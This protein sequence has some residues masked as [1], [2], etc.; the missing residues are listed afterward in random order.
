MHDH[1]TSL[2]RYII[3]SVEVG[4]F[5]VNQDMEVILWNRF[6]EGGS[7]RKAHEVVGKNLFDCFP[8]LP[9]KWLERKIRNVFLLKN[10]SFTSWEQRPYLFRFPHNRPVTGNI[11]CMRQN[12]TFLPVKDQSGEIQ[13]V[14][15]TLFDVTDTSIY[16]EMLNESLVKLE[17][18]SI[19]DGLTGVYNRRYLEE[20]L[21][22]EFGRIKRYGGTFSFIIIDLDHF[23]K[24]NDTYGHTVGDKVLKIATERFSNYL[25]TADIMGRYGGEEFAAILP[26]T[27]L[28]GAVIVAERLRSAL[29]D[30]PL[31]IADLSLEVSASLG[32]AEFHPDDGKYEQLIQ[33]AD[34][35]LYRAKENGRNQVAVGDRENTL[36]TD[37]TSPG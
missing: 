6:M 13:S 30:S 1:D 21:A 4:V 8:E 26:E 27:N 23:K 20:F 15:V 28:A 9:R 18:T 19:R 24:I 35:A 29:T 16:A 11:D 32:V 33:T 7:D 14:C 36:P 37:N 31:V 25:R 22:K 10:Y 2:L 17:E 5:A 34:S 12:C 3:D